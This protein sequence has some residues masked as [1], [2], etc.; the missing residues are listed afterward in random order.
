MGASPSSLEKDNIPLAPEGSTE[1]TYKREMSAK[2]LRCER[3]RVKIKKGGVREERF[4]FSAIWSPPS[5][6]HM[7]IS[8]H[9]RSTRLFIQGVAGLL[10]SPNSA[11]FLQCLRF[12]PKII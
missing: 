2:Q 7:W 11:F 8:Q 9:S 10:T 6:F 5:S 4:L 1:V 3:L 12:R